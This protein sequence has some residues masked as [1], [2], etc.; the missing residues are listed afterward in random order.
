VTTSI[1]T[2]TL[3]AG[4]RVGPSIGRGASTLDDAKAVYGSR[5]QP[6][7]QN[8]QKGIVYGYIV[9]PNLFFTR[10]G[11]PGRLTDRIGVVA[12]YGDGPRDDGSGVDVRGGTLS[13][14]GYIALSET[15]CT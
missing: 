8:T 15:Q 14:A 13:F 11:L 2:G 6:S 12:L 3:V 10:G 5:F 7:R 4:F 1:P 9:K